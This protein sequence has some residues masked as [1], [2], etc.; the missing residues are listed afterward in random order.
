L[1]LREMTVAELACMRKP[2]F[3]KRYGKWQENFFIWAKALV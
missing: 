2:K 1:Y 3:K